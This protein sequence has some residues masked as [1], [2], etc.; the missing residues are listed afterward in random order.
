M[1]SFKVRSVARACGWGSLYCA[2]SIEGSM[3]VPYRSS[4]RVF[5]SEVV[6]MRGKVRIMSLCW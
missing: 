4:L 2:C 6:E 1:F 5:D 3:V